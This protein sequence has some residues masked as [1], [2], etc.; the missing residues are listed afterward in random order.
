MKLYKALSAGTAVLIHPG[1]A[2]GGQRAAEVLDPL[3]GIGADVL[4]CDDGE[5]RA[6]TRHG[7]V[8][9]PAAALR[10]VAARRRADAGAQSWTLLTRE[11]SRE[12]RREG[13]EYLLTYPFSLPAGEEAASDCQITFAGLSDPRPA[14]RVR[15]G[16]RTVAVAALST[17]E[18][19]GHLNLLAPPE[20]SAGDDLVAGAVVLGQ[21]SVA[22]TDGAGRV[23]AR[24]DVGAIQ[25]RGHAAGR[26]EVFSGDAL[27]VA[28]AVAARYWGGA[29]AA[30]EWVAVF[31]G[32]TTRVRLGGRAQAWAEAEIF[33]EITW[34][35]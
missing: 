5:V 17:A 11:G 13:D 23:V 6:F 26:G 21:R 18:E 22:L 10:A 28:G 25:V 9:P 1:P 15:A 27:A 31:G 16:E 8:T 3:R 7:E 20:V 33:A 30:R 19:L 2:P 35:P 14:L 29:E 32:G 12:V 4:A 34:R 24:E